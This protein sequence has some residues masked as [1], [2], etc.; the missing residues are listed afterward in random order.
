M[1]QNYKLNLEEEYKK[2]GLGEH[3]KKIEEYKRKKCLEEEF[4]IKQ[5]YVTKEQQRLVRLAEF[6]LFYERMKKGKQ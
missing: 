2:L 6:I 5:Y 1:T 3:Y 4:D